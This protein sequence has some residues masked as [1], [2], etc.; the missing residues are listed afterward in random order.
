MTSVTTIDNKFSLPVAVGKAGKS[1]KNMKE[2]FTNQV[3]LLQ[4]CQNCLKRYKSNN[5]LISKNQQELCASEC[6]RC[7][8]LKAVCEYCL[9]LGHKSYMPSVRACD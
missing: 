5:L 7:Y 6:Q 9:S 1:G 4:V 2:L 3:K 8:D